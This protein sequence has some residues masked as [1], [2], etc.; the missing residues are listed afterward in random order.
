MRTTTAS[1]F[2]RPAVAA[3]IG[4]AALAGSLGFGT[5]AEASDLAPE[6]MKPSVVS[7]IE[8]DRGVH[9]T[10]QFDYHPAFEPVRE[11]CSVK[12]EEAVYGGPS[13]A[14]DRLVVKC[15]SDAYDRAVTTAVAGKF[16]EG[17]LHGYTG[18]TGVLTARYE[19][20]TYS[21]QVLD[22]S[23]GATCTIDYAV[24]QG[25]VECVPGAYQDASDRSRESLF[26]H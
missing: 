22:G 1:K 25:P 21:V 3:T 20:G 9:H 26:T 15:G 24:G 17:S 4:F 12:V 10:G 11:T 13:T 19:A 18:Q 16:S 14:T 2:T 8:T 7:I 5:N 23:A 6:S